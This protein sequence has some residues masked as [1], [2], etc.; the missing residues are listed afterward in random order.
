MAI[1][2]FATGSAQAV[3]LW[4]KMTFRE[5]LKAALFSRFLGT[6]KRSILQRITELEKTA[7]DTVKYEM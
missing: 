3:N 6:S 5:A 2:E 7:G 1:T 4:S